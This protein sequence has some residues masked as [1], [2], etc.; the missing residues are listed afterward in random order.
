[1]ALCWLYCGAGQ[2]AGIL[3]QPVQHAERQVGPSTTSP[4]I[5]PDPDLIGVDSTSLPASS[6][7]T[8]S[9][10]S[11]FTPSHVMTST[12]S[13]PTLSSTSFEFSIKAINNM[14]TCAPGIIN[15]TY[16]GSSSNILL[17]IMNVDYLHSYPQHNL[18]HRQN[19]AGQFSTALTNT[20]AILN[21]WTW[22]KVD[23]PQG[24]Y[25]IQG[26][27][28][29]LNASS[30]AFFISNGSDTACLFSS[31]LSSGPTSTATAGETSSMSLSVGKIVGVVISSLAGML[32][33]ALA[34]AYYLCRQCRSPTRASKPK[35]SVGKRW[36]SLR[37][38]DLAARSLARCNDDSTCSRGH[39]K[40]MGDIFIVA[41]IG[42]ISETTTTQG[43]DGHHG[44]HGEE[45]E[46]HPRSPR[47]MIPADAIDNPLS[48]YNRRMSTHHP[49]MTL[50][51]LMPPPRII[52]I[53]AF[54]L[55]AVRIRSSMESSMYL[56]TKRFSLPA[57][58]TPTPRTPTSPSRGRDEHPPS[59]GVA[60]SGMGSPSKGVVSVHHTSRKPVPH[61]DHSEFYDDLRNAADNKITASGSSHL[62]GTESLPPLHAM[63]G[64]S[65][66]RIHNLIPD[67]PL[68]RDE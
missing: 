16:N 44:S 12:A 21:S 9:T 61:Y 34:I 1:M 3:A 14:T 67:M 15:W 54:E 6:L 4:T 48:R 26:S 66:N 62:H 5:P 57:L 52:Q 23:Q 22:P 59:P 63:P 24:W 49:V 33:L 11:S 47:G 45:K 65:H 32:V 53:K 28:A 42:K 10:S 8:S 19:T 55:Q 35:Q 31:S 46:G 25:T 7:T 38:D 56:R 43:S 27:I 64:L 29:S 37:S 2:W 39:S 13:A 41:D 30:T 51:A 60:T 36:S 18:A 20:S 68:P 58:A 17:S 40:S 50:I